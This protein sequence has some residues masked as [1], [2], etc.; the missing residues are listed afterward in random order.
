MPLSPR[1]PG[2]RYNLRGI[3]IREGAVCPECGLL[4]DWEAARHRRERSLWKQLGLMGLCFGILCVGAVLA[5]RRDPFN[6]LWIPI[7]AAGIFVASVACCAWHYA[8]RSEGFLGRPIIGWVIAWFYASLSG[9][10]TVLLLWTRF[11]P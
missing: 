2:C 8:R 1:C 3:G 5:T 9:V 11:V 6:I 4:I 7:F 10:M